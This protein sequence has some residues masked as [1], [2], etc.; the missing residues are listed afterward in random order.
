MTPISDAIPSLEE[1]AFILYAMKEKRNCSKC[2]STSTIRWH[3]DPLDT[4]KNLC[5]KCY[6]AQ[7]RALSL[8]GV[9]GRTCSTPSCQITS[10]RKWYK[11]PS[12]KEKDLCHRCYLAQKRALA[13][14]DQ[15]S[16]NPSKKQRII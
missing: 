1:A 9:L 3:K 6:E 12:D 10:T 7:R 4:Q 8:T 5:N 2:P 14:T 13:Q 15:S 11:D 16:S